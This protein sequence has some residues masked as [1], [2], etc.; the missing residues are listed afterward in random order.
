M[1]QKNNQIEGTNSLKLKGFTITQDSLEER[2]GV[3]M[4]DYEWNHFKTQIQKSWEAR[5]FGLEGAVIKHIRSSLEN[6]GFKAH[7][8]NGRLKFKKIK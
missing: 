2:F 6:L 4:S 7:I 8:I 3:E 1:S 5:E